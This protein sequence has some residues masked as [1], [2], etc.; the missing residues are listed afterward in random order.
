MSAIDFDPKELS[1]EERLALID[2]IWLS[3]AADAQRGDS[4]ASSA[5]ELDRALESEFLAEF[6]EGLKLSSAILL[7]AFAGRI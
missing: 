6:T 5:L 3:I 4:D 1:V 7:A 2:R